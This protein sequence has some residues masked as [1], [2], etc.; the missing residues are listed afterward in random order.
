MIFF[1][2]P[3]NPV[4]VVIQLIFLPLGFPVIVKPRWDLIIPRKKR[5]KCKPVTP[6]LGNLNLA[7]CIDLVHILDGNEAGV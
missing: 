3:V 2:L 5:L 7:L 6:L 1:V 4:V